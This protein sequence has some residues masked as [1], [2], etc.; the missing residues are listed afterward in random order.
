MA[1]TPTLT[2]LIPGRN[3][4]AHIGAMLEDLSREPFVR[5]VRDRLEVIVVDDGSTDRMGEVARSKASLFERMRVL[6][7]KD[8]RGK[9]LALQTAIEEVSGDI[10]GFVDGDHTFDLAG[11][12]RFYNEVRAGSDVVVGN[13]R[14]PSSVFHLPAEVI[15]Y[16]HLRAFVGGRFNQ[17][18]RLL[19]DLD[20]PDTQ[21]GFKFFRREA[22]ELCFSRVQVGGFVFDLEV[23]LTARAAGYQIASLPVALNYTNPEPFGEVVGMSAKVWLAFVQVLRNQRA[24]LYAP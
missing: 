3:E 23:L 7:L 14:A 9:G 5:F 19:T 20:L 11:I 15:P 22:A 13:R 12:E 24:G 8:N 16:I 2:L 21:C 1:Q 10:V 18:V 6:T 4:Q 17:L